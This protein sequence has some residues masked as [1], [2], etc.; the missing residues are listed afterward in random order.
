M[1]L[2]AGAHLGEGAGSAGRAGAGL[3]SAAGSE[4]LAGARS[5]SARGELGEADASGSAGGAT[6]AIAQPAERARNTD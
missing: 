2:A 6:W 5:G 3:G 4:G 1:P